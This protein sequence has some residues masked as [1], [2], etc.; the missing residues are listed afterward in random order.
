[1]A[2]CVGRPRT[3]IGTFGTI[4]HR[5]LPGG[6][7]EARARYRDWDGRSR[8]VQATGISRAAAERELKRRLS[9]RSL[10]QPGFTGMSADSSFLA[11][12]DYWLEDMEVEDRLS[13]T[14]RL[15]Y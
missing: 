8:Q 11:L 7:Y 2:G 13:R 1:M 4:G 12:V 6:T 14:T 10:F 9:Q 3:P 15:L 5:R